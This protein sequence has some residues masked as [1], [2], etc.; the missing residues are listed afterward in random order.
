MKCFVCDKDMGI[1][2]GKEVCST[3]CRGHKKKA[4]DYF[5]SLYNQ[6]KRI[7]GNSDAECLKAILA[8]EKK[9]KRSI[10]IFAAWV[11][12]A[13]VTEDIRMS[14]FGKKSFD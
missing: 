6:L 12:S 9:Q 3:T 13:K 11:Q 7:S 2:K 5:N 1:R 4:F 14:L 8:D 10:R